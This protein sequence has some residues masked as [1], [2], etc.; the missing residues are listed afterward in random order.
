MRSNPLKVVCGLSLLFLAGCGD[1]AKLPT[2]A[3]SGPN[4]TLP[5]PNPTLIPTVKIAKAAGWSASEKPTPAAGLAVMAFASGL[6]HP[7]WLHVLPNGDV[8][9]AESNAPKRSEEGRVSRA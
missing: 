1:S 7:R 3:T 2:E 4:P 8:L 9:V 5:E 6:N